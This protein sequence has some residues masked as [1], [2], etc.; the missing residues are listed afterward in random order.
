MSM[1][2]HPMGMIAR[3]KRGGARRRGGVAAALVALG[4]VCVVAGVGGAGGCSGFSG[5]PVDASARADDDS[6]SLDLPPPPGA[7]PSVDAADEAPPRPNPGGAAPRVA[8]SLDTCSVAGEACCGAT[9]ETASCAPTC[10]LPFRLDCDDA[11]DCPQGSLCCATFVGGR[12]EV[13]RAACVVGA[14]AADQ[15]ALCRRDEQCGG[16]R[17]APARPDFLSLCE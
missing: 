14:C 2:I 12:R 11:D 15:P 6:G 4:S 5:S 9:A 17:C 10:A 16:R 7:P 1:Y 13:G 8:C 3:E